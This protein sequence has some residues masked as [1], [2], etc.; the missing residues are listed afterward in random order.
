VYSTVARF[1]KRAEQWP[2]E[3]WSVIVTI[4]TPADDEGRMLVE[5]RLLAPEA[6]PSGLLMPG[7]RFELFEGAECVAGGEVV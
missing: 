7:S 1:E 3:A 4:S 5:I 6:A 2:A